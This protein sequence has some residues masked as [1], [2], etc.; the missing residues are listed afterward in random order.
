[1]LASAEPSPRG[2][3]AA[4]ALVVALAAIAA[5]PPLLPAAIVV[6]TSVGVLLA[7][8]ARLERDRDAMRRFALRDPLT[9]LANRRALDERLG[10]EIA[11]HTRH[12][13]SFAVL[14]LDLDGFKAVNDRFGHDAGDEVLREAAAALVEVVRAQDTVV[15]LGGDE[16]CV[17]APQTGQANADRLTA[18]VARRARRRDRRPERPQREQR[19]RRVPGRRDHAGDAARRRGPRRARGEAA[20]AHRAPA[21][22]GGV[23]RLRRLLDRVELTSVRAALEFVDDRG[24]RDAAQIAYFALLSFIPLAL[25]LVGAFGLVFD[26]EEVRERVVTTVFDNVPLAREDDRDQ[27][28]RTVGDALEGAGSLGAASIVLLLVAASGVMGALRHAIN[29]A[30]DI[31]TRPPLLR[32]KA[33]DLALVLGGTVVLALSL[34]LT[35]TRRLADELDERDEGDSIGAALIDVVGDA[36]PLLFTGIVILFLYRVLPSPR[37]KTREIWPGAV[38]AALLLGLVREALE[39]YF[40]ELSD[41]GALYGSLGAL[42]ALLVFVFAAANVLVF[43]AE[44]A[45]EWSRLPPPEETR[46]IVAKG[47]RR[48]A[49]PLRPTCR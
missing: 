20:L 46:E 41:F 43:G 25:L 32:R 7:L 48:S 22:P 16:F 49:R 28:E 21:P 33:L 35:A 47:H 11:R 34:S 4:A 14:A 23:S 6:P 3:L 39:L 19:H 29:E 44:F 24:H 5:P 1:M 12:G 13:E 26:D 2:G 38:V 30:W 17:L 9:G 40:E 27:L 37:P 31:H 45:S 10:Y 36:L 18:R 42:M 8:R 15:R